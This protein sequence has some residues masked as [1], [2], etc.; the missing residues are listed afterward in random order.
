VLLL[1]V[2]LGVGG[3][4]GWHVLRTDD[5]ATV[6][7]SPTPCR[8]S[9]APPTPAAVGSVRLRVLNGTKRNGLAHDLGKQLSRRGFHVVGVGNTPKPVARTTVVSTRADLSR[10]IALRVQLDRSQWSATAKHAG[11][12]TLVIGRDFRALTSAATA[13]QRRAAATRAAH[14]TASPCPASSAS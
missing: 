4:F 9:A 2:A 7:T 6:R 10:V 3:W 11:V 13:T 14:P 12:L 5:T 8:S 1:L